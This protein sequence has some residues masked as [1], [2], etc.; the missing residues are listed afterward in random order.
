MTQE[1][2]VLDKLGESESLTAEEP[3]SLGA[4][5]I[6]S[7]W[8]A[9]PSTIKSAH[10]ALLTPFGPVLPCRYFFE[11]LGG[12]GAKHFPLKVSKICDASARADT[13]AHMHMHTYT[14]TQKHKRTRHFQ[15]LTHFCAHSCMY[16]AK[17]KDVPDT[18]AALQILFQF[19]FF[20]AIL[21]VGFVC[22]YVMFKSTQQ[23]RSGVK[24]LKKNVGEYV[25][26]RRFCY[27]HV[28]RNQCGHSVVKQCISNQDLQ[29]CKKLY[30]ASAWYCHQIR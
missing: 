11:G 19:L 24:N 21:L 5:L 6:H 27:V 2:D 29:E 15:E 3:R 28:L 26:N 17:K 10:S 22:L 13:R 14:N 30:V 9:A 8:H 1:L 23:I 20:Y 7:M 12:K 25:S 18:C 4:I 16:H